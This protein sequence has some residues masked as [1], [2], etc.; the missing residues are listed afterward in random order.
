MTDQTNVTASSLVSDA[1][2][3]A[4]ADWLLRAAFAGVFVFHGAS[5]FTD[6]QGGAAMMGQPLAI[7]A[8]VAFAELAGG[9]G[10]LAGRATPGRLGD[11]V[12]R[13]AG[14]AVVPVM[15]GA[16]AMVHWG[17]WTFV[18]SESHPMGGMEFQVVLLALGLF[19][20]L[21]GNRG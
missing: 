19:Y 10:I 9:V 12:T 20:A 5:K 13:L 16:I 2:L 1:S 15:L 6:L 14:L 4:A 8:L 21:R 18:P 11:V 7:W 17:R 3:A